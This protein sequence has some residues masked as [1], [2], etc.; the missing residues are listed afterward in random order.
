MPVPRN[1]ARIAVATAA[2]EADGLFFKYV[3]SELIP[4]IRG[5]DQIG[6]AE[7]LEKLSQPIQVK[8]LG[9]KILRGLRH[10]LTYGSELKDRKK[11]FLG[12]LR[13]SPEDEKAIVNR[14]VRSQIPG[15][16]YSRVSGLGILQMS[17]EEQKVYAASEILGATD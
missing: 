11:I 12:Q 13:S 1:Y 3:Q 8:G 16:Y 9:R 4:A 6:L 2:L 17:E 7:K 5:D 14:H 10:G 15:P